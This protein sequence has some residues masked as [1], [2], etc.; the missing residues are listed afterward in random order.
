MTVTTNTICGGETTTS[1]CTCGG[2]GCPSCK[3]GQFVRPRFFAGQ[4]LTEEDLGVL[5]EYVGGVIRA[6]R[7]SRMPTSP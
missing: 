3:P 6:I 5:S 1:T 2:A 7:S 4:L